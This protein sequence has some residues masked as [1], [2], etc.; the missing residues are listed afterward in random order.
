MD[1]IK[2]GKAQGIICWKLDRL[3]RNFIDGGK[4]IDSL[5]KGIIKEIRTYEAIHFPSDNVLMLLCNLV[6]LIN[7]SVIYRSM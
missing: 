3:A 7:I 5:Q 2:K 6:W 4:I 1:D